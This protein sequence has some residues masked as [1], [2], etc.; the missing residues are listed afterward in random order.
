MKELSVSS[1]K[2]CT[3]CQAIFPDLL[4]QRA[5]FK[6]DWHRYNV[7]QAIMGRPTVNDADFSQLA[8]EY[9]SLLTN[10]RGFC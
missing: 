4:E 7:K 9:N 8:G 6:S 1:T 10:F 5:H 3:Y 2:S